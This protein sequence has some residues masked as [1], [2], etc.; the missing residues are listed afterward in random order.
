MNHIKSNILKI[1]KKIIYYDYLYRNLSY[2]EIP[3]YEY[4][5]LLNKFNILKKK[6]T[7]IKNN[8]FNKIKF[9]YS[10][11]LNFKKKIHLLPM[12][13]L[14]NVFNIKEIYN[15]YKKICKNL[16]KKIYLCCELKI[17][18]ISISLI[19]KK[20]NLVQAITRGNGY[21]GDDIISN[22]LTIINIP[23]ILKGNNIPKKINICGEIFITYKNFK[24]IKKK[25]NNFFSNPRNIVSGTLKNINSKITSN[26]NLTFLCYNINFSKP[27]L[28]KDSHFECLK[29]INKWGIPIHNYIKKIYKIKEI[30]NFFYYAN[31]NRKYFGFDNDGIVIKIDSK[32]I[33]NKIGYNNKYPKWAIAYKFKS[34]EKITK[35][36][37]IIF[38]ISRYGVLIPIAHIKPINILGSKIS[39]ITLHNKKNIE[40]LNLYIGDSVI[41]RYSGDVI[42]QII[43]VILSKRPKEAKKIIFPILCP[44]CNSKLKYIKNKYLYKCNSNLNCKKQLQEKI[45]NFISK[46]GF[47]ITAIK[48]NIIIELIKK[49][50]IR[51][52]SDIFKLNYEI[53]SKLNN[54][55]QSLLYKI[56]ISINKSK[57]I[58]LSNFIYSLG[59]KNVGKI[60]SL[61]VA[62]YFKY[63]SKIIY[64]DIKKLNLVPK[65][66]KKIS[67]NIFNFMKKKKNKI[68][69]SKIL[70]YIKIFI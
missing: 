8:I 17:D 9:K 28:Y 6:Y 62:N 42:P 4:D 35:I 14:K 12:L 58:H 41:V 11:T 13:S 63:I 52:I 69:I 48:K 36:I 45:I 26:R 50:Y 64:A 1:K 61:N 16:K 22:V 68:I 29:K 60:I 5:K 34:Q 2:S 27:K 18:G 3:D 7:I 20:G 59:I 33:Q 30:K 53:L 46:N 37:D 44:I 40:M 31:I 70:K 66:S 43:K 38:N 19:Y 65:I 47:N 10:N 21:L 32:K 15:F 51:N 57:N 25:N 54:V 49:K 55:N 67:L 24:K 56:L 39:K 23:L